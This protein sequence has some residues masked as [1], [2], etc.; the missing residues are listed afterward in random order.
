MDRWTL[1][2]RRVTHWSYIPFLF[3]TLS[4]LTLIVGASYILWNLPAYGLTRHDGLIW[5][6]SHERA[7][8]IDPRGPVAAAGIQEGDRLLAVNG[9]TLAS[10]RGLPYYGK[11][12][13]ESVDLTFLRSDRSLTTRLELGPAPLS[14]RLIRLEPLFVALIFW[15]ISLVTWGLRPFHGVTRIFFLLSQTM[16]AMLAAGSLSTIQWPLSG[17]IFNI[18]LTLMAPLLLHFFARFPEPL[19][20]RFYLPLLWLIYGGA[21]LVVLGM[22][23][24]PQLPAGSPSS[25]TIKILRRSFVAITLILALMLLFWRRETIGL[26]AQ[27]RQLLITGLL[28]SLS[29]LLFLSFVPELIEAQPTIDYAW[30]FPF[31]VLMPISYAYALHQG[32]LGK[33]DLL[34]NRTLVYFLLI[35]LLLTFYMV[36]FLG[37]GQLLPATPWSKP[38]LAATLAVLVAAGYAPLR[39]KL[40]HLIDFLF[41]NGWYNYRTVVRKSSTELSQVLDL[42]RLSEQ[43]ME[44]A[45][46]MRFQEAAL[47]WR[48]RLVLTPIGSFGYPPEVLKHFQLPLDS[49]LVQSLHVKP[50][51]LWWDDLWRITIARDL[52]E[53]ERSLA[54]VP[55]MLLW[56]PLVSRGTLRAVLVLGRRQSDMLL[57]SEDVDILTTVGV[58]AALAAD[59]VVL[60][61]T[62]RARLAD[63]ERMRDELAR[64]QRRLAESHEEERRHLARQLHDGAVQ[65]LIGISYQLVESRRKICAETPNDPQ[66]REDLAVNIDTARDEVLSVSTELRGLIGE[67]RPAGLEEFGLT[68]ALEGYVARLQREGG[69]TLPNIH[70]DLAKIGPSLPIPIALCL[71]RTAQ[72]AL[73]N[74]LK[75][76][77]AC[78]ITLRLRQRSDEVMLN[79]SDDGVGFHTPV[80]LNDLGQHD[81]FGLIGMDEQVAWVNGELTLHSQPDVGTDI[82][83]RIPLYGEGPQQ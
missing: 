49:K 48:S 33:I 3:F 31:L 15:G 20:A 83:V 61:E 30:T 7:V 76:A 79:I 57:D 62:L 43:L 14:V 26:P 54:R 25:L 2:A 41:Y 10:T 40:Q 17:T 9:V 68:T 73:R 16:A 45:R 8:N 39:G 81:H 82:L 80:C 6:G 38:L 11:T 72:E 42:E 46:T 29:P 47:L 27:R 51:P 50:Q 5:S 21:I 44:I 75:H 64:A 70:M 55:H 24:L 56:L 53:T 74:A 58:H 34:L 37:L 19:P 66:Q 52:T 18:F 32:Q 77:H 22:F 71:F 35:V 65:Q 59:N 63:V 12:I 67:L 78:H 36:F 1:W 28:T 13:G 4:V 23:V 69:R 60:V